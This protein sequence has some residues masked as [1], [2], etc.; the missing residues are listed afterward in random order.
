MTYVT[1]SHTFKTGFHLMEASTEVEA[2]VNQNR[3]YTFRGQTPTTA[4]PNGVT[5]YANPF[6]QREDMPANLG[7]FA[8]DSWRLNR[9]T[10]N[11]G[12]RFEYVNAEI[13]AHNLPA[14]EFVGA[15]STDPIKD[16]PNWKDINPRIGGSYDLFG[17]GRTAVKAS[18]GRYVVDTT[19]QIAQE[20]NPIFANATTSRG[21]ND[22]TFDVGD[23][24]RGNFIPDC[25]LKNPAINGECGAWANQNFGTPNVR[26][27]YS[28]DVVT[29]WGN[30]QYLWD[31]ATEVQQQ[32][33]ARTSVTVGYY[34]NWDGNLTVT[35]NL[36]VL[37]S[38][39]STYCITAP[40]DSRLPGGGGFPVCGLADV[41][42]DKFGRTN[43]LVK[44]SSD[45]DTYTRT[46]DFIALNMT[47]RFG[48]GIQFGGGIDFGRTDLNKCGVVDSPA[49]ATYDY[50]VATTPTYCHIETPFSAQTQ[51][52][53]YGSY[54]LPYSFMVS[55]VVQNLS[56]PQIL[57][58]Y[59]ATNAE[60]ATS[61]GRNLSS[62]PAN[63][64]AC[65]STALVPLIQPQTEFVDRRTQ[66]DL[67]FS[68]RFRFGAR[69]SLDASLD[70]YNVTNSG[71]IITINNTYS[72]TSTQWQQP[73]AILDARMFQLNG[74][75]NF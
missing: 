51:I 52:K 12:L 29:G 6:F 37:P 4:V 32:V 13:P 16:V 70:V 7:I 38:D 23:P 33:G 46:S 35:D 72:P 66:L 8:Q 60:I 26:A 67:R 63:T 9:L 75:F 71:S 53:L 27:R 25:D 31:L 5:L 28:P 54:P 56:G 50:T 18:F 45:F 42:R 17:T 24:R 22:Q 57:A 20:I 1:G 36:E 14:G 15:R 59:A 41:N 11:L 2:Y 73:T 43:T 68:R 48:K 65:T 44:N 21:W 64:G 39:Y 47:S 19:T 69:Y 3:S 49:Q 61:L 74:R 34:R 62:C 55:G 10:L 30:R 58:T 40:V